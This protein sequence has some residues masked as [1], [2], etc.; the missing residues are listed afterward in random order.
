MP[1]FEMTG[2]SHRYDLRTTCEQ[3]RC[4]GARCFGDWE[5]EFPIKLSRKIGRELRIF[6]KYRGHPSLSMRWF[7]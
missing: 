6:L 2:R 1:A 5:S 4:V 7:R 3:K